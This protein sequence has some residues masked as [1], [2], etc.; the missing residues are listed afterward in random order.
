MNQLVW[1]SKESIKSLF[2][3]WWNKFDIVLNIYQTN[4]Y[5][6]SRVNSIEVKIYQENKT[7]Y[8]NFELKVRNIL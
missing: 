5:R 4:D 7:S 8:N 1:A 2:G 3:R 6:E